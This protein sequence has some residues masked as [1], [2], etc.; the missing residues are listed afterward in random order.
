MTHKP[1]GL[2]LAMTQKEV[3]DALGVPANTVHTIEKR[4]MEKLRAILEKR[5]LKAEDLLLEI[6]A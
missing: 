6:T 4:A 2:D 1:Y 5:N 3:A